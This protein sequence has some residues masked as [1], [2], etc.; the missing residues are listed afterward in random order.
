MRLFKNIEEAV[1]IARPNRFVVS[2]SLGGKVMNAYLPNPGRLSELFLPGAALYLEK[3][4]NK[5]RKLPFTVVAVLSGG[6]PVLLHTHRTNDVAQFLLKE[7]RVPGLEDALIVKREKTVGESRFDF[8][9]EEKSKGGK[10]GRGAKV[11]SRSREI[12]LEVKSCT[13]FCGGVAMFPD[14]VTERGRRHVRELAGLSG[15]N[16]S[17]HVLFII[18]H[19]TVEAFIPDFHTDPAFAEALY[20]ARESIA[21]T[22][23]AVSV[24]SDFT[25][26]PEVRVLPVLWDVVEEHNLDAGA[27][28]CV[29]R[30]KGDKK[31]K[32]GALG[33][34]NFKK[35][36]YT[37]IGSARKNLNKRMKRHG[38][39]E[40]KDFWHIDYLVKEADF[41]RILPV[42]T[43]DDLECAIARRMKGISAWTQ[44]GFGASDCAC[45][46]HLFATVDDPASMKDFHDMLSYFRAGRFLPAPA[47]PA[48]E[49][50]C[51]KSEE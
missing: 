15:G 50:A 1:F 19:P 4:P 43:K 47:P 49:G 51:D 5:E 3:S 9:L 32:V 29:L 27:Y 28:L 39:K 31:I 18:N 48:A 22:P 38:K 34:V 21:I 6:Y 23:L 26:K 17:G 24:N 41:V 45:A 11:G 40:K 14:A 33:A 30:L 46:S 7:H 42:R 37:Y 8:F 10:G 44:K 16:V 35:G 2:C 13:L 25:L 36:Y 12:L 20:K